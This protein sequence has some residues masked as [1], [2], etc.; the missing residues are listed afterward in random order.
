MSRLIEMREGVA[1]LKKESETE[2]EPSEGNTVTGH[3]VEGE[4]GS[5]LESTKKTAMSGQKKY[6][7]AVTRFLNDHLNEQR[8]KYYHSA[9]KDVMVIPPPRPTHLHLLCARARVFPCV[10]LP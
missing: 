4:R 8:Q 1:N 2:P 3:L 5:R 7:K 6:S 9:A 10:T